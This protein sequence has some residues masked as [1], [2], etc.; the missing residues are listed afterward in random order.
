ML[1][2]HGL[3]INQIYSL[4]I[5]L[6]PL[7]F[8]VPFIATTLF[9]IKSGPSQPRTYEIISVCL[10]P[11]VQLRTYFGHSVYTESLKNSRSDSTRRSSRYFQA[12]LP[13]LRDPRRQTYGVNEG[14]IH[15]WFL[16]YYMGA[17]LNMTSF[18]I[19]DLLIHGSLDIS[20]SRFSMEGAFCPCLQRPKRVSIIM[21]GSNSDI[22]SY[23]LL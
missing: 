23:G 10:L 15:S 2:I 1:R 22:K 17:Q 6:F 8:S 5:F 21:K 4:P 18:H 20:A 16:S 13:I 7:F 12:F 9:S 19:P 11:G 14:Q 3:S